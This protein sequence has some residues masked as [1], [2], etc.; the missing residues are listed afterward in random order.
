MLIKQQR[1]ILALVLTIGLSSCG[2]HLRKDATH[3]HVQYPVIVFPFTGA[4]LFY[5]TL[6]RTLASHSICV[7]K[8]SNEPL[9]TLRI[10]SKNLTTQPLV[11]GPDNELR[12]ERLF[13]TI[14]FSFGCDFPKPFTL[15]T[16]RDHQLYSSQHLGDNAEKNL[17]E[18]EMEN[19][20]IE[21]LLRYIQNES[22]N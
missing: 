11:Y 20:I 19:D 13:M 17:L 18:T 7:L 3:L 14:T 10:L 15:S 4:P 22:F 12:R 5:H 16:V 9:P 1:L 21:Q 2:F 8:H 6:Y